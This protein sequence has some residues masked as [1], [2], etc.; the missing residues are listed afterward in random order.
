MAIEKILGI[1]T[2]YGIVVRGT[3]DANPISASSMLIN[4]YMSSLAGRRA[5][6][7]PH[8]DWDFEDEMPANDAREEAIRLSVAPEVETHLVNTV[9]TNGARYY[10]DHAHP[11]YS[12]PECSH[13]LDALLYD[14]AGEEVLRRSMT[15]ATE[16]LPEGQELVV[17]KNNSDGKGN[18]YGCHENYLL[19]RALPFGAVVAHLTAH[20]V[21]RQIFI[22]SGKVG[23][24]SPGARTD[25]V[26]FQITQR[27]DFFEEEVGLETT[28]KRPIINTRDE[29]HADAQLYR[30]LHVIA[31][32]ANMS[33]TATLLKLG[34]T[35]LVLAML[36][37]SEAGEP[38]RLAAPVGAMHAVSR[39]LG[40]DLGLRMSDGST[41][42][43]LEIQWELHRRV[44]NWAELHGFEVVGGEEVGTRILET[45]REVLEG[46]DS[47]PMGLADRLDWVAKYRLF[48]AYRERHDLE[49]NDARLRA[50]DL[51]YH[52]LRPE[53]GLAGRLGLQ[54]ILEEHDVLE[55][56]TEPPS[57]TRAY[58]RGK[59]LE[60]FPAE[61]VAANWDSLVFD[62]GGSALQRVPMM[63]PGRGTRSHVGELLDSVDTAGELLAALG[64]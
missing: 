61:V 18:S 47:D 49:W 56:I 7:A 53:H 43:A 25:E 24:E 44:S 11:E 5:G 41:M 20:F 38:L 17:Y 40:L 9:L 62:V 31:G 48:S 16:F 2:E 58:F 29:P 10:V 64:T 37:D 30:R 35:A 13:A 8:V 63:E 21:T 22:G 52:D 57:T 46:L 15:A 12:A 34:T 54:R 36:E 26:P 6:P 42:T 23:S 32:D 45:W 19:D 14:R 60:K 55:A 51:Q 59:C 28:L 50:M 39:D 27:A 3:A 4:S 33:E 1:E